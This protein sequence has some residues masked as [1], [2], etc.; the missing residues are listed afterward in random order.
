MP[1][2]MQGILSLFLAAAG[3]LVAVLTAV[4]KLI[5]VFSKS[6]QWKRQQMTEA[7]ERGT[8]AKRWELE[9][10]KQIVETQREELA[11]CHAEI[12]DLRAEH[13]VTCEEKDREI[14]RLEKRSAF[15]REENHWLNNLLTTYVMMHGEVKMAA[16]RPKPPPEIEADEDGRPQ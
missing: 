4:A 9:A 2:D 8:T 10:F 6:S 3:G 7:E 5:A 16:P 13:R 15:R 12:A 14:D 1:T 11:R